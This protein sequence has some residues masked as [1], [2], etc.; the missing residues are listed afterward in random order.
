MGGGEEGGRRRR[1]ARPVSAAAAL[2]A[3]WALLGPGVTGPSW[4]PGLK[5]ASDL[6]ARGPPPW[7]QI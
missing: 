6:L 2:R 7:V 4:R 3:Y 5:G 1:E